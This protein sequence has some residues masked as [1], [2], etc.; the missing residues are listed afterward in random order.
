MV[1][2][3]NRWRERYDSQGGRVIYVCAQPTIDY[4]AWQLATMLRSFFDHGIPPEKIHVVGAVQSRPVP[5]SWRVLI[6]TYRKVRFSFYEDERKSKHYIPS[7]RP[8]VLAKHWERYPELKDEVVFYHDSD[9]VF[10][11]PPAWE[12]LA[13][14]STWYVSDTRSYLGAPYIQSKGYGIFEEMC[15]LMAIDPAVVEA[16]DDGCGGAHYIMKS[17]TADFWH[18]V[19]RDCEIL[20]PFMINRTREIKADPATPKEYHEIQ[21]WTADMWAVLWGAWRDGHPTAC[22]EELTFSWGTD[23]VGRWDEFVI[24][25]NA[26]VTVKDKDRLFFKG[27]YI[28]K[29]P[30]E[31]ENTVDPEWASHRYLDLVLKAGQ[32]LTNQPRDCCGGE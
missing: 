2:P 23:K 30:Y 19:E 8:H 15:R 27:E 24:Y 32:Q 3:S 17:V 12:L 21:A 26:G 29:S 22:S 4:Y 11:R 16:N 28:H 31:L 20:Y 7:V 6:R 13:E 14:G 5:M 1:V 25:H 10:T 18:R 9:I